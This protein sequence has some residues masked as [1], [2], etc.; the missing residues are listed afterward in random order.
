MKNNTIIHDLPNILFTV[1]EFSG[2]VV[3]SFILGICFERMCSRRGRIDF[4]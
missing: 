3:I 4:N 2:C 1:L